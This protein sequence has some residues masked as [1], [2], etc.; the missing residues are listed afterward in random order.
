MTWELG[1]WNDKKPRHQ[2]YVIWSYGKD[3]EKS[4]AYAGSDDA[5]MNF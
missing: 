1:S 2:Q 5:A 4:E 3:G